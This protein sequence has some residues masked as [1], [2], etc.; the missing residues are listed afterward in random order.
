MID[1]LK[2]LFGG[3]TPSGPIP[4]S[5]RSAAAARAP[6]K[7]TIPDD[8]LDQFK[9]WY[10]AQ[11]KPAVALLPD[12]DGPIGVVGSRLGGPAWLR[13]GEPWPV[14]RKGVP[15]EFLAQLDLAD[16]RALEGYP[17]EGIVQ[18]FI[19]RNDLHGANFD[20]LLKG[21]Y[22][23][24]HCQGDDRGAL[25]PPPPLE[26]QDGI[27]FSDYSPFCSEM[28]RN[29]GLALK[30]EPTDDPIDPAIK[31]AERRI[32]DLYDRYDLAPL[33]AFVEAHERPLRHHTGGHPAFTQSDIR[34]DA[35]YAEYDRVLL[36][37]TSDDNLM[38]GDSGEAVFMM[39]GADLAAGDF[40]AVVYSW[41]CC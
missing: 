10:L 28:V 21:S 40:D 32:L 16:C 12:P 23:V 18:F 29:R 3:S 1:F 9:R 41:D 39:R 31:D 33:D 24:R 30:A 2:R 13:E 26:E 7:P 35:S 38:W 11:N 37:L 27:P 36:R 17:H 19:G 5:S 6:R 25:H 8:E 34:L 22:L 4:A 15:L 20:D 14:D